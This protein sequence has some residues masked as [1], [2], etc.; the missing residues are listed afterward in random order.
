[1]WPTNTQTLGKGLEQLLE[2]EGDVETTYDRPFQVDLNAFDQS[3][4]FDLVEGGASIKL[5]K[6]NRRS[7]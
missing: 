2:F 4:I 6:H 3:F 1:M 7:E 5:T